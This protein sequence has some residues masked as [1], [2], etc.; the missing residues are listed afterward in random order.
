MLHFV[1]DCRTWQLN[2]TGLT[3]ILFS[4]DMSSFHYSK[5]FIYSQ[6][7]VHELNSFLKVIHKPKCL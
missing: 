7:M 1:T 4:V 6:T 3:Y 5:I 2:K